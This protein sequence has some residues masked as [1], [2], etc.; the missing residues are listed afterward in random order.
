MFSIV[1]SQIVEYIDIS[2][3]KNWFQNGA[4]SLQNEQVVACLSGLLDLV[5]H[6]PQHLVTLQREDAAQL[7]IS[8]AAVRAAVYRA[9]NLDLRERHVT[10]APPLKPIGPT[11]ANPIEVIRD[12][13]AKCN[14]EAPHPKTPD[15]PFLNDTALT[16][17]LRTDLDQANRAFENGHWKSATVMAG[18]VLEALLLWMLRPPW[19]SRVGEV[20][21]RHQI[22]NSPDNWKLSQYISVAG[23]TKM[24]DDETRKQCEQCKDFRNLIHPGREIRL[25]RKVTRAHALGALAAVE[26]VIDRLSRVTAQE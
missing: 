5:G 11:G 25:K 6:V 4:L 20:V 13:L 23:D 19:S 3:D 26:F 18:A 17:S 12:L 10:G 21:K 1:P 16:A 22:S 15:L 24:I 2:F 8:L 14:D 7:I 9:Q